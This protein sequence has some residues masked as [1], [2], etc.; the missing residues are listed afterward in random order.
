MTP[1]HTR[2]LSVLSR[3]QTSPDR[4]ERGLAG[5]VEQAHDITADGDGWRVLTADGRSTWYGR[6]SVE[7]AL[8]KMEAPR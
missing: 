8:A 3:L 2:L 6:A 5:W 4:F 7:A 1:I